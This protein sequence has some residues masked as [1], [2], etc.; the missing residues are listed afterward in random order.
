VHLQAGGVA[1]LG[2]G[3]GVAAHDLEHQAEDHRAARRDAPDHHCEQHCDEDADDARR[4]LDDVAQEPGPVAGEDQRR[5]NPGQE[6]D[7][8]IEQGERPEARRGEAQQVGGQAGGDLAIDRPAVGGGEQGDRSTI[9]ERHP[10][11]SFESKV[12]FPTPSLPLSGRI[13]T[14]SPTGCVRGPQRLSC[15]DHPARNT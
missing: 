11:T 10:D 1:E 15:R 5:K 2:G 14:M 4:P 7:Q 3:N 8:R 12:G 6:E 9:L 13:R